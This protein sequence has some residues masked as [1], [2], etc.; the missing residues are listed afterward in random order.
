MTRVTADSAAL[1]AVAPA[2]VDASRAPDAP[3]TAAPPSASTAASDPC[4]AP[5]AL[6]GAGCTVSD[7]Y[8]LFVAPPE[9]GGSDYGD[10]TRAHPLASIGAALARGSINVFVCNAIY[11]EAVAITATSVRIF[12]GLAC[13][14][15]ADA[16]WSYTGGSAQVIAPSPDQPALTVRGNGVG[17]VLLE[18]LSFAVPDPVAP[19]S[20]RALG[21]SSVAALV[22]TRSLVHLVRVGLHA[23][24]GS[25]GAPGASGAAARNYPAV[26]SSASLPSLSVGGTGGAGGWAACADGTWSAGGTGGDAF[27]SSL[28]TAGTAGSCQ[29]PATIVSRFRNGRAGS[30]VPG[31]SYLGEGGGDGA[32]GTQGAGGAPSAACGAA[33]GAGWAPAPGG[34]GQPGTPGQGGGGAAGQNTILVD[35]SPTALVPVGGAGGAAGGCAGSGGRGGGG[36]GASIALASIDS[37]VA[38]DACVLVATMG[39]NGGPGGD[40]QTGEPG[41]GRLIDG[42]VPSGAGGNGPGGAGGAGGAGG[43]AAG[44]VYT[45]RRPTVDGA[46]AIFPGSSG[47]PGPGGAAGAAAQNALGT[48]PAGPPGAVGLS[49]PAA[50]ILG[51]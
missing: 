1:D 40:G 14:T 33:T 26:R 28:P 34:D 31:I 35:Q 22:D 25:D 3:T 42:D 47:E 41:A 23:G 16:G 39:G 8:G 2:A 10:G 12:G 30:P 38:L 51:L 4:D 48:G 49:C 20:Q 6:H 15:S 44:I 27:V 37:R 32:D 24:R 17:Q 9:S 5:N 43:L 21:A 19:A 18:D 13:P 46:T 11:R 45:V 36:G 29:P 50:P 7:A